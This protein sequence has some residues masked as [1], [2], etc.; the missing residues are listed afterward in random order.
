MDISDTLSNNRFAVLFRRISFVFIKAI[1][2]ILF[3]K[4]EHL[5]I[6]FHLGDVTS[7]HADV[8]EAG[9]FDLVVMDGL[10]TRLVARLTEIARLAGQLM[11]KLQHPYD[12]CYS[13]AMAANPGI[14]Q[15]AAARGQ[16]VHRVGL[17]GDFISGYQILSPTEWNFH[18]SGVV[19]QALLTLKGTPAQVEQQAR[20]L[21][22][23]ID[24]CVAYE[25]MMVQGSSG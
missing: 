6:T 9:P 22:N 8:D 24:P 2:G 5:C 13:V 11:P 3:M 21:I 23:A 4:L 17:D 16:L 19:A 18:P 7:P 10:L 12:E 25:L 20:L 14:G 1:L 15:A